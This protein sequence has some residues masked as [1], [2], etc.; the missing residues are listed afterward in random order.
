[1]ESFMPIVQFLLPEFI[2]ENFNLTYVDKDSETF[3]VRIKEKN[4][5]DTDPEKKNLLSKGFFP[6]ITD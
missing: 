5:A 1:M 4:A 3:H 6:T 2:L